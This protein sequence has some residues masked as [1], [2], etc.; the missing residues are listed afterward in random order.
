MENE[1]K[2]FVANENETVDCENCGSEKTEATACGETCNDAANTDVVVSEEGEKE[3]CQCEVAVEEEA[4]PV[5]KE[6]SP[7]EEF[8]SIYKS[9]YKDVVKLAKDFKTDFET[10]AKL[11]ATKEKEAQDYAATLQQKSKALETAEK[12]NIKS[13]KDQLKNN[14][15]AAKAEFA[16]ACEGYSLVRKQEYKSADEKVADAKK[17]EVK[18]KAAVAVARDKFEKKSAKE[19]EAVAKAC[20]KALL[21]EEKRFSTASKAAEAAIKKLQKENEAAVK[22]MTKA[23]EAEVKAIDKKIEE[24]HKVFA[25]NVKQATDTFDKAIAQINDQEKAFDN[26]I[27]AQSA[28]ALAKFNAEKSKNTEA[29]NAATASGDKAKA[30]DAKK[31]LANAQKN[32]DAKV[33]EL[34]KAQEVKHAELAKARAEKKQQLDAMKEQFR[35]KMIDDITAQDNAKES[36]IIKNKLEVLK[37][38]GV[39]AVME[40]QIDLINMNLAAEKEVYDYT[41]ASNNELAKIAQNSLDIAGSTAVD[42]DFACSEFETKKVI[43]E[44]ANMKAIADL[45]EAMSKKT[46]D[47]N[48]N[49]AIEEFENTVKVNSIHSDYAIK[50]DVCD[51]QYLTLKTRLKSM[52]EVFNNMY[53]ISNRRYSTAAEELKKIDDVVNAKADNLTNNDNEFKLYSASLRALMCDSVIKDN[54]ESPVK[55]QIAL[56]NEDNLLKLCEAVYNADKK[57]IE[58]AYNADL[59]AQAKEHEDNVNAIENDYAAYSADYNAKKEAAVNAFNSAIAEIE[60]Q[61]QALR[62]NYDA[63]YNANEENKNNLSKEAESKINAMNLN[64]KNKADAMDKEIKS[65]QSKNKN[66][67]DALNQQNM[68]KIA[69]IEKNTKKVIKNLQKSAVVNAEKTWWKVVL[70]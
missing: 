25:Q 63:M 54:G 6:V 13:E 7:E 26:S 15:A 11:T 33:K 8:M 58:E 20:D 51:A 31:A 29:M 27:K 21:Q 40:K 57:S 59:A 68:A 52:F 46:A 41:V 3:Q 44:A 45:E 50:N 28:D 10:Q 14:V 34:S 23:Y 37:S 18:A 42:F 32:Y 62:S 67:E 53:E 56:K 70:K 35:L 60:A 66:N 61:K 36:R 30:K 16:K 43:E 65:I 12:A 24:L 22:E 2:D 4:A 5:V 38:Q 69:E 64:N 49:K 9:T 48:K 1:N 17:T 47:Y 55:L 19:N 39:A